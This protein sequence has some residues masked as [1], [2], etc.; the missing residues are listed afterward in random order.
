M[1]PTRL[2]TKRVRALV[3][4]IVMATPWG[5][6][7]GS[8]RDPSLPADRVRYDHGH[9]LSRKYIPV[10][11]IG[12]LPLV[13]SAAPTYTLT[14]TNLRDDVNRRRQARGP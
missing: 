11:T 12:E 2:M 13:G 1:T 5:Q 7:Y 10:H 8:R 9:H 6:T 4:G 14:G 3:S